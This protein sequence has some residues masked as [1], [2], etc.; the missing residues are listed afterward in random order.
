M[1]DSGL[2]DED[3]PE[4]M[5]VQKWLVLHRLSQ[6]ERKRAHARVLAVTHPTGAPDYN[7]AI[8]RD[9]AMRCMIR[10]LVLLRALEILIA[11]L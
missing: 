2:A 4:G 6:L 3:S 1:S 11:M 5:L 9:E 10:L 8:D 7:R